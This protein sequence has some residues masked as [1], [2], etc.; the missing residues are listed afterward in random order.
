MRRDERPVWLST[1]QNPPASIPANAAA[2]APLLFDA[3]N[4]PITTAD[5]WARRRRIFRRR[6]LK[7]LTRAFLVGPDVGVVI[8]KPAAPLSSVSSFSHC[9]RL[10]TL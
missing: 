1:V 2:P 9:L 7:R 4:Q 5:G 6:A 3:E 10:F 8:I